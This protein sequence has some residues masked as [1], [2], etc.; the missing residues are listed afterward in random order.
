MTLSFGAFPVIGL[1]QGAAEYSI[2]TSHA[3]AATVKAGSVLD[4]ATQQLA[5]HLQEQLSKSTEQL[6]QTSR[7]PG[8]GPGDHAVPTKAQTVGPANG[9][10]VI[11]GPSGAQDTS[12]QHKTGLQSAPCA[13]SRREDS[14]GAKANLS[15]ALATQERYPS[16]VN[17]SFPK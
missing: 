11:C 3:A 9:I 17:L 2:T 13:S 7:Q 8:K 5:G 14:P 12:K 10:E 6:Q 1:C 15:P 4:K 16:V